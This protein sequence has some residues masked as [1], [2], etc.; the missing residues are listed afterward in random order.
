ME[1]DFA[2]CSKIVDHMVRSISRTPVDDTPCKHAMLKDLFPQDVYR[3]ILSN[4]PDMPAFR[5]MHLEMFHDDKGVSTRDLIELPEL[6]VRRIAR[7]DQQRLWWAVGAATMSRQVKS[8]VFAG[9]ADDLAPVF[10]CAPGEVNNQPVLVSTALRRETESYYMDP[11]FDDLPRVATMLIYLPEDDSLDGLGTSLY[12]YAPKWQRPFRKA[13]R[14]KRR[15]PFLPNT[16]FYFSGN[17]RKVRPGWHG[18]ERPQNPRLGDAPRISLLTTWYSA[19]GQAHD[20][21]VGIV[22]LMDIEPVAA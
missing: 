11:H 9:L 6:G 2:L 22:P 3:D 1:K 7:T 14:E 19:I 8:A 18:F 15:A 13:H 5:P 12:D 10:G 17:R 20:E 4:I 16:G 21:A